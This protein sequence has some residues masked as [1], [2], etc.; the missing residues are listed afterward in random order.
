MRRVFPRLIFF[1]SLVEDKSYLSKSIWRKVAF[2]LT[3]LI[4]LHSYCTP[5]TQYWQDGTKQPR[6]Y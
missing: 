2:N 5:F 1:K 3:K 6:S 4:E